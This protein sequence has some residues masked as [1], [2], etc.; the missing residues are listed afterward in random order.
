MI[1]FMAETIGKSE[2]EKLAF[3]YEKYSRRMFSDIIPIE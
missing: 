2:K 1:L 3:L